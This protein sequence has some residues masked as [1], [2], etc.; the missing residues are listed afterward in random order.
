M[1]FPSQIYPSAGGFIAGYRDEMA[2]AWA[3]IDLAAFE[4][5]V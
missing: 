4:R 5:A 3:S 1:S 2:R